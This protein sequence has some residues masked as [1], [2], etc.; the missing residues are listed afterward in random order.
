MITY[1]LKTSLQQLQNLKADFS[2]LNPHNLLLNGKI[3]ITSENL[4]KTPIERRI[5]LLYS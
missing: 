5:R 2:I 4:L 3:Y 1:T